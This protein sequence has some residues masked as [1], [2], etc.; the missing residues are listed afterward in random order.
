[1]LWFFFPDSPVDARFLTEEEKVL[2]VK[3]VAEAK[4]GVKNKKFK[5]YQV[6]RASF[7]NQLWGLTRVRRSN[8]HSLTPRHGC[9]LLHLLRLKYPTGESQAD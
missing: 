8:T 3:R 2:A 9:C 5:W 1:M 6:R 4:L 7:G